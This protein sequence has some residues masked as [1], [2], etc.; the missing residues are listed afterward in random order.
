MK[1]SKRGV[2]TT[3]PDEQQSAGCTM[4]ELPSA[5]SSAGF[6]LHKICSTS[7]VEHIS[8]PFLRLYASRPRSPA[9][10]ID[11]F[12]PFAYYSGRSEDLELRVFLWHAITHYF[13]HFVRYWPL[14]VTSRG[15][16]LELTQV[17]SKNLSYL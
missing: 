13:G 6:S 11:I 8:R 12:I 5:T 7:V 3:A 2:H 1:P 17:G 14:P 15:S 4:G 9:I 16:H 10:S